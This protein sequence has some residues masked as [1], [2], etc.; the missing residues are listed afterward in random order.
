[1]GI[2]L[3]AAQLLA[4]S[5]SYRK[6]TGL[7]SKKIALFGRQTVHI[8]QLELT[9]IVYRFDIAQ[10]NLSGIFEK[11]SKD[12]STRNAFGGISDECFFAV[13]GFEEVVV[14]DISDYEG[15][16]VI[17]DLTG[18]IPTKFKAAF[19]F[20]YTGGCLDNV[21]CPASV[22]R[23]AC[24]LLNVTGTVVNFEAHAGLIGAYTTFSPEWFHSFFCENQFSQVD[25]WLL[26]QKENSKDRF[27]Y[28][29]NVYRYTHKFTRN[30]TFDRVEASLTTPGIWYVGSSATRDS[31]SKMTLAYP[32]QLQYMPKERDWTKWAQGVSSLQ[33][34]LRLKPTETELDEAKRFLPYLSDHFIYEGSLVSQRFTIDRR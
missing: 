30:P 33:L 27:S 25:T 16:D 3:Q 15:A 22:L 26:H 17:V 7:R 10:K 8:S 9:E 28:A 29:T 31:E 13:L 2:S 5:V 32:V 12:T 24:D 19:D 18:D 6:G 20:V 4:A 23:N 11:Y 14:F 34:S 1:M 21:F